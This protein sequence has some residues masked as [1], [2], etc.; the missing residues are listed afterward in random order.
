MNPRNEYEGSSEENIVTDRYPRTQEGCLEELQDVVKIIEQNE[1]RRRELI[2]Q[3][4]IIGKNNMDQ[5]SQLV[6]RPKM[7]EP[8]ERPY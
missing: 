4:H 2:E 5:F 1:K 8:S 7:A 6:D 3:F